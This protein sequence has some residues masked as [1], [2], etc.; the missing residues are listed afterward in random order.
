[1]PEE[2]KSHKQILKS[3]SIVGGAQIAS[4]LI[5]ILRTKFVAILLG[6]IGI[7]YLG[8]LQ[9]IIDLARQVTGFGIN[10]S[11][12]KDV[13]ESNATD[14]KIKISKAIIILKRW[15]FW[16]GILGTLLTIIFCVPLSRY[17]FGNSSYAVSIASTAI[18][19]LII[20][21]SG[22]QLALL[23]GLRKINLMAKATFYGAILGTLITVPLYW[24]IGIDGIVPGIV[25]TS[26]GSLVLS[27]WFSKNIKLEKVDLS[28]KETFIGGTR[29]VKLGFFITITGILATISLYFIRSF[30]L[31][32]MSIDAVG[33]FQACWMIATMYLGI[34]LNAMLADFF[35]RLTEVNQD[36]QAVN[37]L[38]NEQLEIAFLAASPMI[39][40][41]IVFAY[42]IIT[43]LYSQEFMLAIPVLQL[44]IAG[45]F[46]TIISWPLG[47]MFLAKNKG[48]FSFVIESLWNIVFVL[49]IYFGWD[50][51]GFKIIGY[52]YVFACVLRFILTYLISIY[53]SAFQFT[54]VN[55]K[56][57]IIFGFL[58]A[59]ALINVIFSSSYF[60]YFI[61][62]CVM[63]IAIGY[64]YIC[65]SKIININKFI[66]NKIRRR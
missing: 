58:V 26:L 19:I 63:I 36:N 62:S 48:V 1:M 13:A 8:V 50:F 21:I 4:I 59:L 3:T 18:A 2:I 46:F 61:S 45:T 55:I 44:L 7:G 43:I 16:T 57:G 41:I 52:A 35:P 31:K 17:S 23:Q 42:L 39:I 60:Q 24:I 10:F 20:S 32:R 40:G 22:G 38:I 29:M 12:I 15:A 14:D 51:Y 28:F 54:K 47:V 5:G 66:S 27:W 11:G 64:S 25:L 34:I 49:I 33:C 65:L 56:Y 37:R 9:S 6:P 30:L 53:L